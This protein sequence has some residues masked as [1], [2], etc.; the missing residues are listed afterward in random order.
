MNELLGYARDL[1]EAVIRASSW[2]EI[3]RD[4]SEAVADELVSQELWD[5]ICDLRR[6]LESLAKRARD[7]REQL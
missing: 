6:D 3:L 1:E 4:E 5:E 7:V 2:A